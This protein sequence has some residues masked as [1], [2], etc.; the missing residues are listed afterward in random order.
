LG[1]Y[2][3]DLLSNNTVQTTANF[4]VNLFSPDESRI[5]PADAITVGQTEI[6]GNARGDDFGQRELWPWLAGLALAV[7]A[8]EWWVFHRGSALP[9]R[10]KRV[11]GRL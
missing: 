4:A 7:L 2:R 8:V 1:I 10:A 9:T 11:E 3:V 5:A 6:G